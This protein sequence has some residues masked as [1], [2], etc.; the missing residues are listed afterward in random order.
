[1]GFTARVWKG[2]DG[3]LVAHCEELP[4][5]II[6]GK[7]LEDVK[8]N[9]GVALELSLEGALQEETVAKPE[10]VTLIDR[11]RFELVPA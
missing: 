11:V 6:Q 10:E 2:E 3:F 9:I 8:R 1:M 7:K 4:G 5:C